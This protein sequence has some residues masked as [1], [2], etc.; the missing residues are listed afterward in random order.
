[1]KKADNSVT[2]NFTYNADGLRTKRTNGT[3]T[4]EYIYNGSQLTQMTVDGKTL[5]FSYD[6]SGTPL[7]VN[8]NGTTYY[9]VTNIQGDITAILNSSGTEVVSYT[10][11]TWGN[12]LATTGSLADDIGTYN[13]LRYRGYVYDQETGFYY[14][15][16]RYYNPEIG[17]FINA[18]DV[19]N[20]GAE[21][22]IVGLNIFAYCSNNPANRFDG[23]GN[24]SLPNWAKIAIGVGI[25]A[26]AAA[27]TIATGGAAA[28]TVVAAVH[29]VAH[30]AL[31]GAVTQGAIGAV[32]GAASGAITHRLTTGSWE[33]AANAAVD[34]AA[35][36]FMTGTITGAISGAVSSPYCFVA[37][38]TVLTAAGTAAIETI[39][40]GD[41]VWAW[42]EET[43]DMALKEV[44][45]T[46]I[47]ET[48]ELIHVHVNGEEIITTPSHPFYSPVK[49]WTSA[50]HLRAGDIL[51]LVNGEYV[52]VEK[53]QHEILEVPILVYNF[54]VEDYHTYYV[55]DTGVLV[56]NSCNKTPGSYEIFTSDNRV[57]VGKGSTTRMQA[58][59]RRLSRKGY[60][61]IDY[62]WEASKNNATA[63]VDEY[64]K[65][66][67][68]NFDFNGKLINKIMSPG[69]KIF[70]SW[71]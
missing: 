40:K 22:S 47:N 68:Y 11:D 24:A 43:G 29:C 23:S 49:G 9:Y 13:P 52:V 45:E 18:D 63:F 26:A 44:V 57:Y 67:K 41:M 6:A 14:L 53:V 64:M 33:G 20:L 1:M 60:D 54:Q 25:I 50:V 39:Q 48:D 70:H 71:L 15:Q 28:G 62:T 17:R 2:W 21:D 51:V 4:Y 58:S 16:S 55:S 36:G 10:Y 66:A 31:V 32:S 19:S 38:T 27:V 7:S 34:G 3:K 5:T 35:T 37:G 65:M 42:D 69:F 59:I 12:P 8:Y 30:G 46:Y 61:I 56:H